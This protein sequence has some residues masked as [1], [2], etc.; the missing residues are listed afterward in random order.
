MMMPTAIAQIGL[1]MMTS[2]KNISVAPQQQSSQD[3]RK[4][5]NNQ[6]G[7]GAKEE[8]CCHH[9]LLFVI[10]GRQFIQSVHT[11]ETVAFKTVDAGNSKVCGNG[12][13]PQADVHGRHIGKQH[14]ECSTGQHG[15]GN[16]H[17]GSKSG[18]F[19]HFKVP[20]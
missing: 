11:F 16:D 4:K 13:Q 19:V 7:H 14:G 9:G 20:F 1:V 8:C 2:V 3:L 15:T 17:S 12:Q 5:F 18:L 10:L 6:I